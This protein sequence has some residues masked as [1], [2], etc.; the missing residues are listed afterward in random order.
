MDM[1]QVAWDVLPSGKAPF[2][3]CPLHSDFSIVHI[4]G[5]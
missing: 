4:L 2:L 1:S 5:H 3:K